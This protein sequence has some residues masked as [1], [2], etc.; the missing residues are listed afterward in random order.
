LP[1]DLAS[2]IALLRQIGVLKGIVVIVFLGL[3]GACSFLIKRLLQSKDDEIKRLADENKEY[4]ERFV[5]LMDKGFKIP[6]YKL[7]KRHG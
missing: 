1:F 2:V 7:P 5:A 6:K 3:L 4:R